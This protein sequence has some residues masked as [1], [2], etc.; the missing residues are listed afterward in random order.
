MKST[1]AGVA[2]LFLKGNKYD[3]PLNIIKQLPKGEYK[4][5]CA[6]WDE[7]KVK[8]MRKQNLKNSRPAEGR[9]Q[10]RSPKDKQFR[11]VK[12]PDYRTK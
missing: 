4:N 12:S 7:K 9:K 11:P 3:L 6:P 10:Q 8:K 5:T 1:Y 2:G